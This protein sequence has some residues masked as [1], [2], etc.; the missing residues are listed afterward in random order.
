MDLREREEGRERKKRETLISCPIY[1]CI[2]GLILVCALTGDLQP[3]R[4]G[5]CSNQL[6][7]STKAMSGNF[8]LY[9]RLS[10]LCW[11]FLYCFKDHLSLFWHA[12]TGICLILLRI[13]LV[14]LVLVQNRLFPPSCSIS[15]AIRQDP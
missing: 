8:L 1:L 12:V 5:P 13:S 2:Q 6:S 10:H 9:S 14:F 3:W 4:I 7:Y 11:T 15:S